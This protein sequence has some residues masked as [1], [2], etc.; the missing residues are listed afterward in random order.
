MLVRIEI[1]ASTSFDLQMP[2]VVH[3]RLDLVP[4]YSDD[5][6]LVKPIHDCVCV[7]E[8]LWRLLAIRIRDFYEAASGARGLEV[9]DL[10]P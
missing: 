7:G 8:V 9:V 3:H 1:T 4:P 5:L 10:V 6:S 2:R